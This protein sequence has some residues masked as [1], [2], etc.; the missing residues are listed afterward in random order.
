M[1]RP[2]F[3]SPQLRFLRNL[4]TKLADFE[5]K[6]LNKMKIEKGLMKDI[7]CFDLPSWCED[8]KCIVYPLPPSWLKSPIPYSLQSL[9]FWAGKVV[10]NWRFGRKWRKKSVMTDITDLH[11]CALPILFRSCIFF[12]LTNKNSKKTL[13]TILNPSFHLYNE[14]SI[15]LTFLIPST[16]RGGEAWGPHPEKIL[17]DSKLARAEGVMRSTFGF[18]VI[19]DAF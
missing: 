5:H 18:F 17:F 15:L 10:Q 11:V 8:H 6:S 13:I 16:I 3:W 12:S 1:N 2:E 9:S 7:I 4:P 14:G 19:F